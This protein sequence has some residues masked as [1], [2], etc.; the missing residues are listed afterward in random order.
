MSMLV[1]TGICRAQ[2]ELDLEVVA[3]GFILPLSIKNAGDSRLFVVERTGAIKILNDDGSVNSTPFLDINA[4]VIDPGGANNEGGLLGMVF[5]PDYAVNGYFYVNYVDNNSNTVIERY[6]VNPTDAN[7]ADPSSDFVILTFPQPFGN[8]NGGDLAFGPD[9][10][11][12]IGTGDGGDMGDPSGNGQSLNTLLG[13]MLRIDVDGGSPYAIPTSNPYYNDGDPNTFDE[14][15]AIG[16]RNPYRYTFDSLTDEL[17]IADVG[18]TVSEE[19]DLIAPTHPGPNFGWR[20]YEGN[21]EFNTTGCTAPSNITFP[22]AEYLHASNP[23]QI[24]SIIGG[25]RY[26]GSDFP[27]L[28]GVYIFTD[29]CSQR[30]GTLEFD[31]L[32][33]NLNFSNTTVTSGIGGFGEDINGEVYA[34]SLF[35]GTVYRVV[36]VSLGNEDSELSSMKIFPNPATEMVSLQLNQP[37]LVHLILMDLQG[38]SLQSISLEQPVSELTLDCRQYPAGMYLLHLKSNTGTI[39]I[40]KL[41]LF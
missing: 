39:T 15:W 10:Y 18:E 1:F 13:K 29:Y 9:G 26:R 41:L 21:S 12:Y 31:G 20:C 7:L 17:W 16:L 19:I 4:K 3:S 32:N 30:L 6:S 34:A 14:I 38:K 36:E 27:G 8:H 5:H 40:K 28:Y 25:Y 23:T 2:V 11:L 24:C 37:R 33:W 35:T 22:V